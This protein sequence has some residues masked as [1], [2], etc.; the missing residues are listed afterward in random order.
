MQAE[1]V[2]QNSDEIELEKIAQMLQPKTVGN[3]VPGHRDEN[4]SMAPP[5]GLCA[6]SRKLGDNH[7]RQV[8]AG[9]SQG[10]RQ[11]QR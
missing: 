6:W 5:R 3:S 10:S 11:M 2:N 1:L 7:T 4:N 8:Q 9:D